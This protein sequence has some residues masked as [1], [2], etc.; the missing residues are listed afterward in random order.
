MAIYSVLALYDTYI[1]TFTPQLIPNT[2]VVCAV[3]SPVPELYLRRGHFLV[4]LSQTD[5]KIREAGD[6][7]LPSV[8]AFIQPD[9]SPVTPLLQMS[10]PTTQ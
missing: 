7:P 10:L 9:P 4:H 3:K 8:S 1:I 6:L 5:L 2:Y